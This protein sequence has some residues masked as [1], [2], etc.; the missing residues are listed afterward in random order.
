MV[1][2]REREREIVS[3]S[4]VNVGLRQEE[5]KIENSLA[6]LLTLPDV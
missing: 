5:G 2:E 1:K 6:S 3:K 4:S